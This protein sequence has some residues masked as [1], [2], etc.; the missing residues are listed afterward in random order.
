MEN[1]NDWTAQDFLDDLWGKKKAIT[2]KI[3]PLDDLRKNIN[4]ALKECRMYADNRLLMGAFRYGE[5]TEQN[6]DNYDLIKECKKRIQLF[7]KDLNYEHIIDALNMLRL[8]FYWGMKNGGRFEAIDDGVVH[9][10]RVK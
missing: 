4:E 9:S 8:K 1:V 5:I 3:L 10:E 2:K 7:E 6:F